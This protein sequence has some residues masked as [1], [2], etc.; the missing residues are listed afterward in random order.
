MLFKKVTKPNGCRAATQSPL[1]PG[2][3]KKASRKV[4]PYWEAVQ[5]NPLQA[6]EAHWIRT[7]HLIAK[8]YVSSCHCSHWLWHDTSMHHAVRDAPRRDDEAERLDGTQPAV[9]G[10]KIH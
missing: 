8:A 10:Q 6:S 7:K 3:S 5:C 1:A 9:F 4:L 2:T